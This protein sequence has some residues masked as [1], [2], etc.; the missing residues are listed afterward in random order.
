[1]ATPCHRPHRTHRLP[2]S[3]FFPPSPLSPFCPRWSGRVGLGSPL[4]AS[5]STSS[6]YNLHLPSN[7]P[8][9]LL[10]HPRRPQV[11]K[12]AGN[13]HF[14]PGRSYQQGSMHVHDIAPFGDVAID[15]RHTIHKLSFGQTF[16]GMR[17]PLDG[18][19]AG[20]TKQPAS[21]MF[22][23]F[24]KVGGWWGRGTTSFNGAPPVP[25]S[26]KQSR[27][28]YGLVGIR[29]HDRAAFTKGGLVPVRRPLVQRP[30]LCPAPRV[31]GGPPSIAP[32]PSAPPFP[33]AGLP[34]TCVFRQPSPTPSAPA[35]GGAYVVHGAV[36]PHHGH[37]PVLGDGE[38]PG[39][40]GGGGGWGTGSGRW[41]ALAGGQG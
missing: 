26:R 2:L 22:Q 4:N 21:G 38:L 27:T 17:N 13:F 29:V 25:D 36:Q 5:S 3:S 23:Y 7:R 6:T 41:S 31:Y 34:T 39:S 24:L 15:F 1:M 19:Q 11:N 16:P 37:Q 32:F 20:Y 14:A 8:N 10:P 33:H 28:G 9:P 30:P 12:V 18:A 35:P 40:A